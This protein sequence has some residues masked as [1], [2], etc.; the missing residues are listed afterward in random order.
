MPPPVVLLRVVPPRVVLP[1][2]VLPARRIAV[3]VAMSAV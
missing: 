3:N 2:V 1:R